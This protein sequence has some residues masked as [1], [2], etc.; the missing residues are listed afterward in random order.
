MI[1]SNILPTMKALDGIIRKNNT[2]K[3]K[4]QLGAM[5]A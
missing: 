5:F 1:I 2:K 4:I 3:R